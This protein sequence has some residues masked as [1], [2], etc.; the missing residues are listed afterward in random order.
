MS[1][2]GL[3]AVAKMGDRTAFDELHKRH[4]AKMLGE[5]PVSI[6]VATSQNN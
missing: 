2:E 4:A 1:D 5:S 6:Y 3:V